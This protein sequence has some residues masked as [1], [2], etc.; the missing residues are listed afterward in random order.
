[1]KHIDDKAVDL[2]AAD[3]KARL[4]FLRETKGKSGWDD[5]DPQVLADGVMR[6]L[7]AG[8]KDSLLNAANYMMMM[9]LRH[10]TAVMVDKYKLT[11]LDEGEN[12]IPVRNK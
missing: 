6:H 9:H 1:M 5:C 3:M 11:L 2:F 4:K 10:I 8:K 7:E 12:F